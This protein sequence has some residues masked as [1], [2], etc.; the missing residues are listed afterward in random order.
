MKITSIAVLALI[1]DEFAVK[2]AHARNLM[3][4]PDYYDRSFNAAEQ[5]QKVIQVNKWDGL[6]HAQNG[7]VY[8][9]QTMKEVELNT[10]SSAVQ[11]E[12]SHPRQ[13]LMQARANNWFDES[14]ERQE[15][16]NELR[17]TRPQVNKFDGLIHAQNG[18]VYDPQTGK[19]VDQELS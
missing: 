19:Q 17:E 9:P 10:D 12:E 4:D 6:V 16:A 18:K 2:M 13:R 7:K 3:Q 11:L 8:D 14:Y 1:G 5:N 15:K